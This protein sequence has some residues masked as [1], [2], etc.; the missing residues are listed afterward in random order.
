MIFFNIKIPY[1]CWIGGNGADFSYIRKYIERA[2]NQLTEKPV[3]ADK[4]VRLTERE[5]SARIA[6]CP[7][8]GLAMA[9]KYS[10]RGHRQA[11]GSLGDGG[12]MHPE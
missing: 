8:A 12:G 2:S 9:C 3:L 11:N 5:R 1:F 6:H 4:A 7:A 10:T